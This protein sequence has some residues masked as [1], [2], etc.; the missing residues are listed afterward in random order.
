[1]HQPQQQLF[2]PEQVSEQVKVL[3]ALCFVALERS[4]IARSEIIEKENFRQQIENIT[5]K[6]ITDFEQEQAQR[7]DFP[8][9]SIELKCFGSLAS[10]FATKASDMDLGLFS[11]Y[12]RPPPDSPESPI[13]RL[14]EKALLEA[15]FG[16]RLLTRTR[17]PIIK[18]CESPPPKL[19]ADLRVEREKWDAGLSNDG[20]AEDGI[21][22]ETQEHETISKDHDDDR[23]DDGQPVEESRA[24]GD[25]DVVVGEG[26]NQQRFHLRQGPNSSLQSYYNLARRM[27][28]R[29]GGRDVRHV[30]P[31]DFTSQDWDILDRICEG[32]VHG[33]ADKDLREHLQQYPSL[34]FKPAYNIQARHSLWTV[35]CQVE[36][37]QILRSWNDWMRRYGDQREGPAHME[38]TQ[39]RWDFLMTNPANWGTNPTIIAKEINMLV[40]PLKKKPLVQLMLLEQS[41]NES[42]WEYAQRVKAIHGRA[43]KESAPFQTPL[44]DIVRDQYLAGIRPEDIRLSVRSAAEASPP[45]LP[46]HGPFVLG[47]SDIIRRHT[48]YDLARGFE[49]ALKR[50]AYTDSE[51]EDVQAYI[52]ILRSPLRLTTN[53]GPGYKFVIPITAENEAVAMRARELERPQPLVPQQGRDAHRDRLEFPKENV[54]VQCDINFSAHLALQNTTLLRC[55]SHSDPRVK[56]MV[57]FVKH[58]AKMRGI[59]SGYRGTLSSYGYVLMVL[60]Y[61]VNVAQPFVCPNLQQLAPPPPPHFSQAEA[62]ESMYLMGYKVHFWR[63]EQEIMHLAAANQLNGNNNSIGHLLRGFFEYYAQSGPLSTGQGKGFDWGR[64]VLSL[65]TMGGLLSKQEK[66]WTGAKTV[67]HGAESTSPELQHAQTPVQGQEPPKAKP[68]NRNDSFKEIRLRYLCAIEDPFEVEHNVARTV[69]HNGIV[70]IRD[71]F[72]RAWRLIKAAGEGPNTHEDLLQDV[73]EVKGS[74]KAHTIEAEWHEMHGNHVFGIND[75]A[76]L[77]PEA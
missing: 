40:E 72:R 56:P 16:A 71:E 49:K 47:L 43:M 62:E 70:S 44:S 54:G 12:S 41:P 39:Q 59:N 4:E 2:S 67:I 10:G 15:G 60:H 46:N 33:L 19:L 65:R 57:L 13:P 74:P 64:D 3:E 45:T 8:T 53:D 48:S 32:F 17:V 36:G 11:P 27:L 63:N 22:D 25:F 20:E 38:Y 34:S 29:A 5:R 24:A 77:F 58:W 14:V 50:D 35:Y 61:L 51:K 9:P 68:T 31:R 37:E 26:D 7:W 66:G 6:V 23:Q 75:E 30:T 55:Y 18:L 42:A 1:M 73:N 52:D 21:E 69:T 28:R 76:I